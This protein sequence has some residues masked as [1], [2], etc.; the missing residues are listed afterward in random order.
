MSNFAAAFLR[1]DR[2]L[3]TLI[4]RRL[5]CRILDRYFG[6]ITKLGSTPFII[7]VASI[8]LYKLPS[9]GDRLAVNLIVSQLIIHA[10]KRIINRSRPYEI[11]DC[12]LIYKPPQ[13]IYSFPSGHSGASFSTALVLS[14][15][16]PALLPILYAVVFSVSFSRIYL[17]FHYVSDVVAGLAISYFTFLFLPF[18]FFV[19]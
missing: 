15:E 8:V 10:F 19:S 17:G 3:F 13:C 14:V 5:H 9:I 12:N 4:N 2:M 1:N 7:M 16:F 11:M 6:A 18:P